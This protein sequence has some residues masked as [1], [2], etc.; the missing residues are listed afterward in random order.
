M[1]TDKQR[2]E[3]KDMMTRG[4]VESMDW[5][6]MEQFCYEQIMGYYDTCVDGELIEEAQNYYDMDIEEIKV[7]YL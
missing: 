7:E 6:T 2:D 3:L 5:K 4:T 1:L